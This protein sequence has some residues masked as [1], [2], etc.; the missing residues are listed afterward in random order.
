MSFYSTLPYS[1]SFYFTTSTH[2]VR[3]GRA[4]GAAGGSL[5][6][7]VGSQQAT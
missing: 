7:V 3:C 6:P 1:T 2:L 4:G 5:L